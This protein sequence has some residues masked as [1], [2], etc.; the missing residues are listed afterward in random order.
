M[1]IKINTL[2]NTALA[3]LIAVLVSSCLNTDDDEKIY[4]A[5]EERALR[6]AYIDDLIE[7]NHDIDTTANGVYYVVIEEGEGEY[8][9]E[10]DSLIVGYAGY[11][12]DGVLFDSSE[13]HFPD[14]KMSFVLGEDRMIAGWEEGMKI[15]NEG[16]KMQ[17]IIPSELAYG[18]NGSGKIPPYQTLVFVVKLFEIHPSE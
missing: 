5:A 15:M 7:K 9:S 13:L 1:N 17:F 6:G 4:S 3:V 2:I 12:I 8:A 16:A 11:F 18:S 10:G 14:G